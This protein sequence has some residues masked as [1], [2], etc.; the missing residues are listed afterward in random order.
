M[1]AVINNRVEIVKYFLSCDKVDV[2][3]PRIF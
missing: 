2:K 1:Y 3:I